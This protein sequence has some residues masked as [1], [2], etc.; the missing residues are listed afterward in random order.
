MADR[1]GRQHDC[2]HDAGSDRLD[3]DHRR[4]HNDVGND[5]TR[6]MPDDPVQRRIIGA[7]GPGDGQ[8]LATIVFQY[9]DS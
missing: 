4:P 8:Q 9:R 7:A 1:R 6:R 3:L 2:D 5:R